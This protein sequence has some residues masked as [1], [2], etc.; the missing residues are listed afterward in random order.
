MRDRGGEVQ[1]PTATQKIKRHRS[2]YPRAE[3]AHKRVA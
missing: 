1:N 2:L 3:G